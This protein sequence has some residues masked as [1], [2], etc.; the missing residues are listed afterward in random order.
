MPLCMHW[1]FP[2]HLTLCVIVLYW[3]IFPRWI[4]RIIST[5]N[6]KTFS[7]TI[8][9]AFVLVTKFQ[10]SER[11]WEASY[12]VPVWVQ[13][14]TLLT[15]SDLQTLPSSYI[16]LHCSEVRRWYLCRHT[17]CWCSVVCCW[18]CWG[19]ELG[20]REQSITYRSKSVET[21]FVTPWIKR[22]RR[23]QCLVLCVLNPSNPSVFLLCY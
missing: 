7:E 15:A 21:V 5:T 12:K 22:Y 20:G 18:D 19:R 14:R 11:S 16:W 8:R 6:L 10:N 1:T 23:R 13:L 9:T 4:C 17:S 2:R 3:I